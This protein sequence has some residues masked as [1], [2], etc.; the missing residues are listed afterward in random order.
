MPLNG[1]DV[2]RSVQAKQGAFF[3]MPG[4]L[5]VPL[6]VSLQAQQGPSS[7]SSRDE[8][9]RQGR[10]T[11]LLAANASPDLQSLPLCKSMECARHLRALAALGAAAARSGSAGTSGR[12]LRGASAGVRESARASQVRVQDAGT[13]VVLLLAVHRMVVKDVAV[14]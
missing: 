3:R 5:P 14:N 6:H 2:G 13:Q 7:E 12:A 11:I 9:A 1:A 10:T 4:V 8:K